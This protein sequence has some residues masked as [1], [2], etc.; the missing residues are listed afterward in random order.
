[1]SHSLGMITTAEGVE[2]TEQLSKL[3]EEGCTEFQGYFIS[4]PLP[5]AAATALLGMHDSKIKAAG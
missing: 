3:H 5:L 2:T 4:E 1:M